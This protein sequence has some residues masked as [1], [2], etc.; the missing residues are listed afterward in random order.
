MSYP[1]QTPDFSPHHVRT[2][3]VAPQPAASATGIKAAVALDTLVANSSS[4]TPDAPAADVG[5]M[6]VGGRNVRLVL[7]DADNSATSRWRVTGRDQFD[8]KVVEFLPSETTSQV[9]A[10][11]LNGAKVFQKVEKIEPVVLSGATAA[12]DTVSAG[13]GDIVGLP[14]PLVSDLSEVKAAMHIVAANTHTQRARTSANIDT[15][16]HALK[17]AFFGG[18]VTAGDSAALQIRTTSASKGDL[19]SA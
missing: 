18:A 17:A 14:V 9:G 13:W 1:S 8:R 10:G 4:I 15:T 12:V 3:H 16:N 5:V 11:T 19:R 2:I 6:P 7:V